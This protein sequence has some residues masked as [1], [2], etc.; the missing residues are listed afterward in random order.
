[1]KKEKGRL[2]AVNYLF[3]GSILS[4]LLISMGMIS[5]PSIGFSSPGGLFTFFWGSLAFLVAAGFVSDYFR[6]C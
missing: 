3:L 4:C 1:M 5:I 6:R 2:I